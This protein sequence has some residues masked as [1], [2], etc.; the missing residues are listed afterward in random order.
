MV[1]GER[2]L[3]DENVEIKERRGSEPR[4]VKLSAAAGEVAKVLGS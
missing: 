1:V 4:L 2:N 3:K